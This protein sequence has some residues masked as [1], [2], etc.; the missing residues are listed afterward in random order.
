MDYNAI[1][2]QAEAK[3]NRKEWL[4]AIPLYESL[5]P[6]KSALPAWHLIISYYNSGQILAGNRT[7][8]RELTNFYGS[9]TLQLLYA[10]KLRQQGHLASAEKHL[11]FLKRFAPTYEDAYFELYSLLLELKKYAEAESLFD[12]IKAKFL[13]DPKKHQHKILEHDVA[14]AERENDRE[15]AL[16]LINQNLK[17]APADLWS[18]RKALALYR[19]LGQKDRAHQIATQML[20]NV[21]SLSGSCFIFKKKTYTPNLLIIF[22]GRDVDLGGAYGKDRLWNPEEYNANVLYLIDENRNW[23]MS[24]ITGLGDSYETTLD[25]LKE[26]KSSLLGKDGVCVCY[27]NSMGGYGACLY[28]SEL[29]ADFVIAPGLQAL[30]PNPIG[31][32]N[33]YANK[34]ERLESRIKKAENTVFHIL[35]GEAELG[36]VFGCIRLKDLPNVKIE[37]VRNFAHGV[38]GYMA[39]RNALSHIIKY[40]MYLAKEIKRNSGL[41]R[42]LLMLDLVSRQDQGTLLSDSKL[43]TWLYAIEIFIQKAPKDNA[44]IARKIDSLSKVITKAGISYLKGYLYFALAKLWNKAGCYQESVNAAVKSLEY[45]K[46]NHFVHEFLATIMYAHKNYKESLKYARTANALRDNDLLQELFVPLRSYDIFMD[47][48]SNL[49][50]TQEAIEAGEEF[51]KRNRLPGGERN[52]IIQSMKKCAERMDEDKNISEGY[53]L[54]VENL[55]WKKWINS[56]ILEWEGKLV[57]A[58]DAMQEAVLLAPDNLP[59]QQRLITLLYKSGMLSRGK[60][61]ILTDSRLKDWDTGI[62]YLANIYESEGNYSMALSYAKRAYELKPDNMQCIILYAEILLLS[63][64]YREAAEYAQ[65]AISSSLRLMALEIMAVSEACLENR[66]EAL[67]L[68]AQAVK[69]DPKNILLQE[70]ALHCETGESLLSGSPDC[71]ILPSTK[72]K[73]PKVLQKHPYDFN[74]R[75]LAAKATVDYSFSQTISLLETGLKFSPAWVKGKEFLE[76][77]KEKQRIFM[78]NQKK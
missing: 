27:G 64:K 61:L 12:E 11:K 16:K 57:P 55:P 23:Y 77:V 31:I 10:Q 2:N 29:D 1:F 58:A 32:M 21:E 48:L 39:Y 13:T 4:D 24:G 14:K 71:F 26:L 69:E 37:T 17:V 54:E 44:R 53:S 22:G 3:Y 20:P 50:E 9:W 43:L 49:G 59:Y 47:N 15:L 5:R 78:Q 41:P 68:F 30:S 70:K 38:T 34:R 36:D 72:V 8:L 52:L 19:S 63:E 73:W 42:N 74:L 67:N 18:L 62:E 56:M 75:L 33:S 76:I 40:Y 66:G 60:S 25:R 45:N 65:K 35:A 28:G 46:S 51:L 6:F 7:L